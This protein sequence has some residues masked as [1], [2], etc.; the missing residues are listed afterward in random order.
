MVINTF[1]PLPE[2]FTQGILWFAKKGFAVTLFLIGT[3][4]S[5]PVIKTVGIKAILLGVLL[6][7]SITAA[8][9]AVITLF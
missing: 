4:L 2:Q 6:W 8:T 7:I 3:S 9:F 1:M 5:L